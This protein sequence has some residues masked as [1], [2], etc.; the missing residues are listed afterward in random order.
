MVENVISVTTPMNQ[1]VFY[2]YLRLDINQESMLHFYLV[3]ESGSSQLSTLIIDIPG[4]LVWDQPW[5][6]QASCPMIWMLPLY[7]HVNQI[8]YY[9]DWCH[10]A[11]VFYC[12]IYI[13]FTSNKC[14]RIFIRFFIYDEFFS[15]RKARLAYQVVCIWDTD[16]SLACLTKYCCQL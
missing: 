4:D 10:C 13:V 1:I 8:S 15:A 11:L 14:R 16:F 6:Q 12:I 5:V 3:D 7:L 9:D 2:D